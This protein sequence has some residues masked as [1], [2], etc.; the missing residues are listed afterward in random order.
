VLLAAG[1][2]GSAQQPKKKGKEQEEKNPINEK[3][4]EFAKK[5]LGQQVGNGE[6]WT[7]ANEAAKAAGAK[8]SPAY[9]DTPNKGDYVWGSLEYAVEVRDGKA[10]ETGSAAKVRPGDVAQL[11][12]TKFAGRRPGGGTYTMSFSHHTAVVAAVSPDGK[13]VT[14]LHQNYAGK[15]TVTETTLNLNDVQGGWIKFYQPLPK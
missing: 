12:E 6:C 7:L 1:L 13:V 3:I 5:Q 15:K 10:T 11:R 9:Q 8:S 4:A 2:T 14:V